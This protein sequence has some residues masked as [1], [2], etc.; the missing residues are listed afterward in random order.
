M[1]DVGS[2]NPA[3]FKSFLV[4]RRDLDLLDA[5]LDLLDRLTNR[6]EKRLGSI[7]CRET[8]QLAKLHLKSNQQLRC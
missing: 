7:Q 2:L 5:L 6:V 8:P 1:K 3:I 4:E